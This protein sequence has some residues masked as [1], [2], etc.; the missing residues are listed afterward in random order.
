MSDQV[1]DVGAL[2]ALISG[3]TYYGERF[4]AE[5]RFKDGEDT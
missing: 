4:P 1:I 2:V 3:W 5:I